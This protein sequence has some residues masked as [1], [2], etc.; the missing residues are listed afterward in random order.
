MSKLDRATRKIAPELQYFCHNSRS[1]AELNIDQDELP[2]VSAS[3][4]RQLAKVCLKGYNQRLCPNAETMCKDATMDMDALIFPDDPE[5]GRL[6]YARMTIEAKN[7][8]LRQTIREGTLHVEK[9]L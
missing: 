2:G 6:E 3:K 5:Y 4:R 9:D 8:D 7:E 1:R